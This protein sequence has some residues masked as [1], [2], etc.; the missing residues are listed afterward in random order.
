MYRDA[1]G[2]IF[3]IALQPTGEYNQTTH[4]LILITNYYWKAEIKM[5]QL[6]DKYNLKIYAN[7]ISL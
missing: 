7:N 4:H 6:N 3:Y 2:F 1:N 5:F